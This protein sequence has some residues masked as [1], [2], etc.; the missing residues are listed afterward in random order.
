MA[1]Y[2]FIIIA[3][4]NVLKPM[5]RSLFVSNMGLQQMPVLYMMLAVVVGVFMVFYLRFSAR[6][7]L[8]RLINYTTIIL[9]AT[10]LLFWWLLQLEIQ[11]RLLYYGL[12]IW[13]SIYGMVTTTQ[14]WLLANYVFNSREAKRL[15]P[16]LIASAL[17][18]AIMGGYATHFLV[19]QIGGT[20]NLA[21]FCIALLLIALVCINAGWRNRVQ[22]SDLRRRPHPPQDP[23]NSFKII[24]EATSLIK[25]SRHLTYLLGIVVLTYVV[26]QI[27]DFQ[28]I[29]FA[30]QEMVS[31]DALTGFLGFW[32]SNLSVIALIFQFMFANL[33]LQKFGV[34][35]TILF[36]PLA[37][38]ITSLSVFLS[39]GLIAIL[40]MKVSD[41]AFRHSINRV[42]MELLYLPLPAEVKNKT[43][44]L[45]DMLADRFARG[46]AGVLLLIFFTGLGLSV[47]QISLVSLALIS[48]WL[49]LVVLT[50][51]EYVNSFR[52]AIA[53]RNIDLESVSVS[54][55]EQDTIAT[56]LTA[57][58]SK[59]ERQVVYALQLL[60]SVSDIKLS[61]YLKQNL[62]Q[63]N[64]PEVRHH[65]LQ[66]VYQHKLK[67]LLAPV[68]PLLNDADEN[69]RREAVRIVAEFSQD[70]P[71]ALISGWLQADDCKFRGAALY[72]LA[73][74]GELARKLLS[75]EAIQSFLKGDQEAR[76]QIAGALGILRDKSTYRYLFELLQDGDEKVKM[77]AIQ[78]AGM[79]ADK[80]FVQ[81]LITNL[82]Y[83]AFREPAREALARYGDRV[84]PE[85]AEALQNEDVPLASRVNITK[86][87][88]RIASQRAVEILLALLDRPDES[89]RYHT[90]K[91]LNKLRKRL[92]DLTFDR[93]VDTALKAE[94]KRYF[95]ILAI[96]HSSEME[97]NGRHSAGVNLLQQA[98]Q[99]R[100][101]DHLERIFRL[102][103]LRY[104]PRDIYN[105]F[106]ASTSD[107][108]SVRANAV[109]F[110]DNILSKEVKRVL[111]PIVEDWP[112][113]QVLQRADGYLDI[114]IGNH[115]E[116][117]HYLIAGE[118]EWLRACAL[119]VVGNSD[120]ANAFQH[121]I[122]K[123]RTA[124]SL[125]VKE[126]AE[127]LV[128]KSE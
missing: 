3:S 95:R 118:D 65:T 49:V 9:M 92:P 11:S 119:Y 36:L 69:V 93:R 50:A 7:R 20:A 42:G 125:L 77:R 45:L 89:L 37:L 41:G 120:L 61:G 38:L 24:A 99:E 94:L 122:E 81:V 75:P 32:I 22:A 47:A 113:E 5:T 73:E 79:T 26:V 70:G 27:A 102:L 97:E 110:L 53:K 1:S 62:F 85:L 90:I 57:L 108:M 86:V 76:S 63:H 68:Q 51:R 74:N 2:I 59:N 123:A 104:P 80:E 15:F 91:A 127:H 4:Y 87:L 55:K 29:A 100:L 30:S 112:V 18:G 8:D 19:K 121:Q 35:V 6:L 14:F 39:Y 52:Q 34:K 21:F 67:N 128:R 17:S 71:E 48:L 60:Q 84:T 107:N 12:F 114:E 10:L 105:A 124:Q 98:L 40:A 46:M 43:K 64:S 66:L 88:S 25:N 116:A 23:Q 78:S 83:H 54:I 44:A 82:D 103:G 31:L 28:F 115:T 16:I 58:E 111:L 101:D 109:E 106:A 56:L 126:T 13:A 96:L 33:I 117:L 72:Y